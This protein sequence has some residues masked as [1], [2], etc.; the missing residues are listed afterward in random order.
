MNQNTD[1]KRRLAEAGIDLQPGNDQGPVIPWYLLVLQGI[2]GWLAALFLLGFLGLGFIQALDKPIIALVLGLLLIGGAFGLL[3]HQQSVFLEQLVLASSLAGQLLVAYAIAYWLDD[4][5]AL[6]W[7]GMLILHSAL[8]VLMASQLHRIFSALFAGL[9]LFFLG[10]E[11]G[12]VYG[13]PPVVLGITCVFWLNEFHYPQHRNALKSIAMGLTLGLLVMQ[14]LIRFPELVEDSLAIAWFPHWL[15]EWLTG[16]ALG[17]LAY[18]VI[19]VNPMALTGRALIISAVTLVL[20]CLASSYAFGLTQ[21]A[22]LI[23]LGF[24]ISHRIVMGLGVLSLLFSI[25]T[26]YYRL[27]L[28]LLEKSF[29]LLILGLL[30]FAVRYG[31]S[32]W[33]AS[34]PGDITDA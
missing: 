18:R 1:A 7:V 17:Y 16:A 31:L 9:S 11:T 13:I 14:Y 30:F 24:A 27:D 26:Y 19:R 32:R 3:L 29:T 25:S 12:A 8:A 10:V 23:A 28:T 22:A 21:G 33:S 34:H 2:G 20:L 6:F 5:N 4:I 15:G